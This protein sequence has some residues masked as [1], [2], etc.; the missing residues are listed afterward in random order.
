MVE[1]QSPLS[2]SAAQFSSLGLYTRRLTA[3]MVGRP[4][5][6]A[7]AAQEFAPE[8]TGLRCLIV[9]GEPGIGKTRLL[10]AIEEL[11]R[12][13]GFIPIGVTNDEEIR[14]PFLV[15]R[16]L[17]GSPAALEAVAGAPAEQ[18]LQRVCDALSSIDDP[19]LESLS[20][21]RKLVRVFDL[22]AVA[23]R[24]L[25]AERP[26]TILIDDMQWADED[27]LR[28]IR[29]MVRTAASSPIVLVL[30]SRPDEVAFV[31]EAVTLLA[32]VERMG[33]V[34]RLK[35]G[36]FSQ[37]ES[38]EFLQQLLGGHVNLSSAATMH[39]QAEGVPFILAEQAQAYRDAGMVQQIDGVWTLAGNAERLLPTAVRTLIQRRAAHLPE[40]SKTCLAEA[41]ILGRS[42]SLRDLRDLKGRLA[43]ESEGAQSLAE[44]LAPAAAAGLLVQQ[45][46]D[47]PADYSFT[48]E[49]VREYAAATLEP[50]RRRAI[51]EAIVQMLTS[52]GQPSPES[53]ALVAQHA[54]AAGRGEMCDQVSVDAA[55]NALLAHAPEEA[56]RLVDRAQP[57]ASSPQVRV[58]LLR[59]Q[60]DALAM[61]RRPAQRL[62]CLAQLA[63]LV[64]AMGDT[65]LELDVMLRRAAA[66]RLSQDHERAAEMASRVRE[67]AAGQGNQQAELAAC[68][69]LGQNLLRNEMGE[70]YAPT[71][72]EV[73][74]DGATETFERAVAVAEELGE[75]AAIAAASRELGIIGFARLRSAF[76][77]LVMAGEHI[78]LVKRVAA[79]ERL[80]DMLPNLPIG[81]I[82]MAADAKMRRALEIYE[83]IGDR[84]G[85]MSTIIAMAYLS[86]APE[87]HMGGS[88]KRI[89]EIRRLATQMKSLTK[90]SER[91]LADAQ[92]LYGSQVYSRA[93]GFPDAALTKGQES[94][95]AARLLGERS[96]MF[97]SAGGM[98]LTNAELGAVEEAGQWL[99][100]AATI[101]MEAPSPLRGRL[102]ASWRGSV[103]SA[104]GD[105]AGM[106]EHLERAV[107]L[108]TD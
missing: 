88:A 62:E 7:A 89:E 70:G 42:F 72:S 32:D 63:A 15:A 78:E 85:A 17:F 98:A 31:N 58:D 30:A 12:E 75:E 6:L 21:D 36:R 45:P 40:A 102:L 77:E 82:A 73:D 53:L 101:A 94:Y 14:G 9:E 37:L 99:D 28:M 48:H 105:A 84:Q 64:E 1:S 13:Q 59:L 8:R 106:R 47:A 49:R 61:L 60:D 46:D 43:G 20:P 81:P 24:E 65:K 4:V 23:F 10:V 108:A 57:V 16:S 55:R 86:W 3:S 11:S 74:L 5:E 66:L 38:T 83:R 100:R 104:A 2:P 79:G 76:I 33:L 97:A 50:T 69:E 35:L 41:A 52:G 67:L 19:S 87:I 39:A 96:L 25:A 34:R 22:A 71:S 29:Y 54:M 26:L 68:L 56:L 103:R 44:S 107:Q 90:E 80:K 93:K 18:A 95:D 91:A 51:H 27:S 92:M